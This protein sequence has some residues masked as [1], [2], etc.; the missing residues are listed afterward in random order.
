MTSVSIVVIEETIIV[1]MVF[2]VTK[3]FV[4][5]EDLEQHF[6]SMARNYKFEIPN[7]IVDI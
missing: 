5:V 1:P 4:Y 2:V 6:Y 7:T 3:H